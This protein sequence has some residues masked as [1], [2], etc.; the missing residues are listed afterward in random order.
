MYNLTQFDNLTNPADFYTGINTLTNQW[1]A[2]GMV[3]ALFVV[4]FAA[5][6]RYDTRVA[7]LA[8]SF[9]TLVFSITLWAAQM[10][11]FTVISILILLL[12]ISIVVKLTDARN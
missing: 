8:S 11:P 10:V 4:F 5:F 9:I 6:K 2:I 12:V 7:L 1:L 3:L